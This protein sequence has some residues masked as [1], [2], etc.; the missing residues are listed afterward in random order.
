MSPCTI[1]SILAD[2]QFHFLH[3]IRVMYTLFPTVGTGIFMFRILP[4]Y[5]AD[6]P[7]GPAGPGAGLRVTGRPLAYEGGGG[8]PQAQAGLLPQR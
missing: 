4:S 2:K 3:S 6:L 1:V 7:R 5:A 8:L